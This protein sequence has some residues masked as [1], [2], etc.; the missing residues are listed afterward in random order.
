ML[1][2]SKTN[3]FT[4]TDVDTNPRFTGYHDVP[5]GTVDAATLPLPYTPDDIP[6]SFDS[7]ISNNLKTPYAET[8]NLSVQREVTHG[9]IL[10]ASYVGRLG[11]HVL[12]NLDV[13]Q[14]TN[15]YDP[16]SGQSYFAAITA[17]DKMIDTGASASAIP[18][19][20]YFHNLFPNFTFG[21]YKGA[22][23]FYASIKNGDRGNETDTLFNADTNSAASSGGQSFRFF[24]PQTSSIYAQSTIAS[25]NYHALQVSVRHALHYGMEYD[26]NYTYSKSMD[27]GSSPERCSGTTVCSSGNYIV[28]AFDPSGQYAPSD[29]DV[30]HNITANYTAPLPFGRNMPFLNQGNGLLERLFG[31]FQLNGVV[32]YSSGF[33]FSANASGNWGTNFAV[34][35]R[36]VQTGPI[37]TGGHRYVA[38]G[39]YETALKGITAAQAYANLRYAYPGESGQRN[40]FRNDGYFSM[41]D[42]LSK[43]FR[44]F[45]EQQFKV[46]VEVFNVTNTSRFNALNT[47]GA[48]SHFGQYTG[49]SST[50]TGLLVQPRQMQ[51]S[52][53]YTF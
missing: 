30:R 45:H 49:G 1:S 47:N 53:K 48:S 44:T 9:M 6:F 38:D 28:N 41:D 26:V 37:P 11:R 5:L 19:S 21:N 42:G 17:F 16:I 39:Q 15:V 12:S 25:S 22:Q 27:Q 23:A 46:S 50:A 32:H 35:S 18:D 34:S 20:G 14:P 7:S 10:T 43:S 4:Y 3:L 36:F 24:F 8:F 13:A 31:G 2:L 33:P 51:F 29:F 40:N 52:G